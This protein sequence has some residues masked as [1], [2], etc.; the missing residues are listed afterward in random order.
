MLSI[1]MK[2]M[3]EE[4][5]SDFENTNLYIFEKR[6]HN[7]SLKTGHEIIRIKL[8]MTMDLNNYSHVIV[9][10]RQS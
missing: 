5:M 2:R 9:L 8:V 10:L 7:K 1:V 4:R 6:T 3:I